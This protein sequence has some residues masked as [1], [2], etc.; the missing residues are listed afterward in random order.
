METMGNIVP[1]L[2]CFSGFFLF[3]SNKTSNFEGSE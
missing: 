3:S 2:H 1:S